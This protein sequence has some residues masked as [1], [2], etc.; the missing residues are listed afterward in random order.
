M[1][2]N[3]LI[4][5]AT[6]AGGQTIATDDVAG[7]QH[8]LVKVEFGT[9][10][11][12]TMVS[13]GNPL[14][15]TDAAAEAS[16]ASID[17]KLPAGGLAT[18]AKQ[19]TGNTSLASID[20][21]LTNPLPVSGTVSVTG[22]GDASAANQA[23]QITQETAINTVLGLIS[24]AIVAAG[25]TGSISAKLRRATQGLED[26]KTLIVL[27]AGAN[28]IGKV[29]IDQTTP[30]TTNGVQ[31]NAALPAGTNAI[32]AITSIDT[33]VTP[34]T[35]AANLG[36][37]EDSIHNT[38]DTGVMSLGVSN[39]AQTTMN[40]DGDYSIQ[41]TDTK[42]NNLV[43]GN[44]AHDGVDTGNPLKIGG[45][46]STIAP[47]EV[48]GG[49]RVN[50]WFTK[51]GALNVASGDTP[52]IVTTPQAEGMFMQE[53]LYQMLVEL[54]INNQLLGELPLILSGRDSR[55]DDI[56]S[57]RNDQTLFAI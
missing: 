35:S 56:S 2:D 22:A 53:I 30:G 16:L 32:G 17:G 21:K 43:V 1:A 45:Y 28:I 44:I 31:V 54:K 3:V 38:G 14:P 6:V 34:G 18:S 10:G 12:A 23:L 41:A 25:A 20:S 8:E 50:G 36:K 55:F 11:N 27:A 46:A 5:A 47:N 57:F 24:D 29:G 7:I 51:K 42:G 4:N 26:L 33:S 52:L 40:A 39:E 19:D 49:D 37:A 15:V 48:S 13:A 9:D